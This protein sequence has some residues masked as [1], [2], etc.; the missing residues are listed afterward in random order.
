MSHDT[1]GADKL[2][3]QLLD[4]VEL[5]CNP[6]EYDL[7]ENATLV[8]KARAWLADPCHT[9]DPVPWEKRKPEKNDCYVVECT[10]YEVRYC[11]FGAMIS[12]AGTV[13]W[14]WKWHSVPYKNSFYEL[15][16]STHW[17]PAHVTHLPATLLS[18]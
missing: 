4:I 13:R 15:W 8:E 1:P 17:L 6:T 12:H 3:R 7:P 11:W 14:R 10:S 5:H 16:P 2:I 9:P 18:D